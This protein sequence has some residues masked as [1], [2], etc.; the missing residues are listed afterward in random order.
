MDLL[1]RA[2]EFNIDED[3]VFPSGRRGRSLNSGSMSYALA[4][5]SSCFT[6]N[7]VE[8]FTPHDLRRSARSLLANLEV[9]DHVAERCLGHT[10]GSRI[11]RTYNTYTYD[12]EMRAAMETLGRFLT[13]MKAGPNVIAMKSAA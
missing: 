12:K 11:Q 8:R 10:Y 2:H 1:A 4:G 13:A 3:I 7:A 6:E 9:P 5:N